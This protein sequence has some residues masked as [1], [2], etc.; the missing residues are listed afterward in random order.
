M[1]IEEFEERN[2]DE[3]RRQ[4][5]IS[6]VTRTLVQQ[7]APQ[8]LPLLPSTATAYFRNP[9]RMLRGRLARDEMLG[10]GEG[11]AVSFLTP[12][13]LIAATNVVE[14]VAGGDGE[15]RQG[16]ISGWMRSMFKQPKT[17]E[18]ASQPALSA[19]RM[20]QARVIAVTTLREH[21]FPEAQ[22]E[23]VA[24]SLV[25]QLMATT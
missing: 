19:E 10:F 25:R 15:T 24:D 1:T 3:T 18:P 2:M 12:I 7:V 8:E 14:F 9:K 17:H 6:D 11:D 16:G 21:N 23:T 22:V 4:Q 13:L 5:L 20:A